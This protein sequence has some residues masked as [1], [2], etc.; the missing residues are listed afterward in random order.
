MSRLSDVRAFWNESPCDGQATYALRATL[1]YGK[2]PWLRPLLEKVA[3]GH[4]H[5]VE[6]GCGQGTD[7]VT[8]C[9]LLPA[10]GSYIGVDMS[11]ASLKSAHSAAFE[12]RS[13][14]RVKPQFHIENAE[15]L[16]F[17]DDSLECIV[18]FGALHHTEH[19]EKAIAEVH[20]TLVPG[21]SAYVCLY[22]TLAPKVFIAHLLR[23]LQHLID[24]LFHADRSLYKLTRQ[25]E[26]ETLMGTAV[27][28]C[29]GAPILHSYTAGQM[30]RLFRDFR[31]VRLTSHGAGLP[32][33]MMNRSVEA[34]FGSVLGYLWLA[35][36][37]K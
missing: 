20:R 27:S 17:A 13:S 28:E 11:G 14:L 31:L 12:M 5:I 9:Q 15:G 36:L 24:R 7:G 34:A 23:G 29:F 8:L 4:Q 19:T 3:T 22:R 21:G 10:T 32:P 35:E 6:V 1:R 33:M 18:S 37:T 25:L 2:E 26:L 16:S 30:R